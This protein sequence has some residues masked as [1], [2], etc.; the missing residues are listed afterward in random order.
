MPVVLS[1]SRFPPQL[2][3]SPAVLPNGNSLLDGFFDGWLAADGAG[4][5]WTPLMGRLPLT[6][7]GSTPL[8]KASPFGITASFDGSTNYVDSSVIGG[9]SNLL[10][11]TFTIT[12]WVMTTIPSTRQAILAD[13][14][15][16]GAIQSL[17]IE[18]GGFGQPSG[19]IEVGTAFG[20]TPVYIDSGVVATAG[21]W[22]HIGVTITPNNANIYVNGILRGTSAWGT[23]Q[24]GSNFAI[25]RAGGDSILFLQGGVALPLFWQR[26]LSAAEIQQL[27]VQPFALV[28]PPSTLRWAPS[29][30][31]TVTSHARS[32]AVIIG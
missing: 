5:K 31:G 7:H 3:P 9:I 16:S 23:L 21:V 32:F 1:R 30:A 26:V 11:T 10:G 12:L 4:A 15:S 17:N 22:Y 24:S 18:F 25:G 14:N 20:G 13:W 2:A 19:H 8:W 6:C 28:R 29:P 27:Y